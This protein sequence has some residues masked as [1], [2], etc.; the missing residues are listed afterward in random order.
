MTE[1]SKRNPFEYLILFIAMLHEGEM[2][3]KSMQLRRMVAEL[4]IINLWMVRVGQ[5]L[6]RQVY[7][8]LLRLF[9][10]NFLT[11]LFQQSILVIIIYYLIFSIFILWRLSSS[12]IDIFY[13][14]IRNY[15]IFA[16]HH[17]NLS[18]L[19]LFANCKS[20][21]MIVTLFAWIAHRF[22]SSNSETK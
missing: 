2:L 17:Q 15:L 14:F 16:Y 10:F 9:S 1:S 6:G 18:P 4:I 21:D 19:I 5:I 12:S 7:T 20:L 8:R 22:V 13:K 11:H 3:D